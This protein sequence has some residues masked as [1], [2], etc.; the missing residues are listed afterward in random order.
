MLRMAE[1]FIRAARMS[2]ATP[3]REPVR[4]EEIA[5]EGS[6]LVR[7][8]TSPAM[9]QAEEATYVRYLP[10]DQRLRLVRSVL[11]AVSM[12]ALLSF[13]G[14][15]RSSWIIFWVV[16]ASIIILTALVSA[17]RL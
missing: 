3:L 16:Q 5:T 10:M 8:S 7:P 2:A 11:N 14:A 17:S 9:F 15:V 1:E 13:D 6:S 12:S 4:I